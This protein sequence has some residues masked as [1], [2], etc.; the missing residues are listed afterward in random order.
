M[1]IFFSI[2]L[3]IF[4]AA[5][6]GWGAWSIAECISEGTG[7]VGLLAYFFICLISFMLIV[8]FDNNGVLK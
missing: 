7:P 8:H 1:I 3:L 6:A 4:N 5:C 2:L